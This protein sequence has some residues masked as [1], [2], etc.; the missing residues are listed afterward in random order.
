MQV[1]IMGFAAVCVLMLAAF[2]TGQ[3]NPPP[4]QGSNGA[5]PAIAQNV[6]HQ[7][8]TG[9][10]SDSF[11]GNHHYMLTHGTPAECVR[12]CIAHRA[13]YVLLVGNKMYTLKDRPGHSLDAL[14]SKRATV[15][16]SL[17]GN[18]IIEIDSVSAAVVA[19]K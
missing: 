10:V 11:C 19:T 13:D 6:P 15:T 7:T 8:F 14:A 9:V 5:T 2:F 1:K 12:Y 16:G 17:L 4:A 18:N 3:K